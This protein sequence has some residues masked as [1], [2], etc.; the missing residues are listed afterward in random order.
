ML[1]KKERE[2]IKACRKN[3]DR[4][5]A[6]VDEAG[7]PINTELVPEVIPAARP[8]PEAQ[9]EVQMEPQPAA[10]EATGA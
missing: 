1:G 8:A 6:D 7:A 9:M 3:P 10:P 4:K 2:A 5:E